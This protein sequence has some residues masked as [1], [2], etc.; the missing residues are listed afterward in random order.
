MKDKIDLSAVV[1][2]LEV[3]K[4]KNINTQM[5]SGLVVLVGIFGKICKNGLRRISTHYL[6]NYVGFNENLNTI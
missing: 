6:G 4:N 2:K 1:I 3:Q 5:M